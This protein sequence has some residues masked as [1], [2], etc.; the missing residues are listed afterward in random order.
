M[1][2]EA[3]PQAMATI[4]EFTPNGLAVA[5]LTGLLKGGVDWSALSLATAALGAMT[6]VF[7]WIAAKQL[8]SGFGVS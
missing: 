8:R 5:Q 6:L 4:G 1:P 3:M 2:F 7:F